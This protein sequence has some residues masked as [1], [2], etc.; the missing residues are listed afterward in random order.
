MASHYGR[1]MR[2]FECA[3]LTALLFACFNFGLHVLQL[4]I[5][6]QSVAFIG[7]IDLAFGRFDTRSHPIA[8]PESKMFPGGPLL[9]GRVTEI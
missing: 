3:A 4:L 7:G 2:R 5:L 6:D 8:D 1:I 9:R